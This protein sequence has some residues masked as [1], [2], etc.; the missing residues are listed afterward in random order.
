MHIGDRI[1]NLRKAQGLTQQALADLVGLTYIQIGRYETGKSSPGADV[2]QRIAKTLDTT[3][4]FLMNGN[5]DE[6]VSA[7]LT[8]KELLKQFREVEQLNSED[9][10]VVKTFLDAFITKRKIQKLA[11]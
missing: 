8:D 11:V 5:N 2:L 9:K 6:A 3:T 10:H 4:D 7:Q 1:K